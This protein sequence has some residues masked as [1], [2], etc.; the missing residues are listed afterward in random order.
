MALQ[1][2]RMLLFI[3]SPWGKLKMFEGLE[4]K[5][6]NTIIYSFEL[7]AVMNFDCTSLPFHCLFNRG[8][9][10]QRFGKYLLV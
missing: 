5:G 6:N 3:T 4:K 9:G 8:S 7:M 2:K 1:R 10:E